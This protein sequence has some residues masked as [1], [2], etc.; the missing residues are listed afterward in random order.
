MEINMKLVILAF[1]AA[2]FLLIT[3]LLYPAG[4]KADMYKR[5][6]AE[7]KGLSNTKSKQSIREELRGSL[8]SHALQYIKNKTVNNPANK[9][10]GGKTLKALERQLTL[11]GS[12]M[13]AA[14]FFT[15]KNGLPLML[16]MLMLLM[17]V[18][19]SAPS[20]M[21]LLSMALGVILGILIPRY[22][23]SGRIKKRKADLLDDLPEVIDLLVVSV[24]AGLGFDAAVI[25]LYEK[26]KSPVTEEFYKSLK[27]IQR[28]LTR[29]EAYAEMNARTELKEL[30][31]LTLALVQAEMMGVSIKQVIKSQADELRRLRQRRA[32]EKAVK[33]P[34]KM[35]L[36]TVGFIFPVIFIILM[37]PA[38]VNVIRLFMK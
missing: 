9:K 25:R 28:G 21:Y 22:W 3:A 2:V 19:L 29:K 26:N 31:A 33:A 23:L 34:I 10:S 20:R 37:A 11:A 1:T 17:C 24:E 32:E 27:D 18:L 15:I 8:K 30:S 4:K 5:R 14:V 6:L 38:A 16:T 12:D 35:M 13:P 7:I 36:P